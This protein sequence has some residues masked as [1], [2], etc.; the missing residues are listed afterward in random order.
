MFVLRIEGTCQRRV[1]VKQLNGGNCGR[2]S[3]K[4]NLALLPN[5]QAVSDSAELPEYN[6]DD[7][8][9]HCMSIKRSEIIPILKRSRRNIDLDTLIGRSGAGSVCTGCHLLLR[10]MAGDVVWTP[11]KI[12]SIKKV[13]D[14]TKT[15]RF[16]STGK[17]FHPARA[18]QHIIVQSYIDGRWELRRYTLTTPAEETRY[19]EIT[20][21]RKSGGKFS[22]WL[23]RCE[24]SENR[25]RISQPVGDVT[26]E[27]A[28]SKP[29]IC[30]VG[31]I[32][33][34]PVISFIRTIHEKRSG[35]RP[36]V[37]DYSELHEERLVY[38]KELQEI[39]EQNDHINVNFR[40][41]DEN[42][43]INQ[44]DIN[45]LLK[46]YPDGEFYVCGPPAFSKGIISCLSK[47]GVTQDMI[48]MEF[49]TAPEPRKINPSKFYFYLGL[50]LFS[51]FLIQD[52]LR[53]KIPWLENLQAQEGYKIYSGIFLVLYILM[54]FVMPYN[55]SCEKPHVSAKTYRQHKFRGALAPLIFY[56]HSTKFGSSY[57]LLL[58]SVYFANF[59]VGLFNHERIKNAIKRVA[60]FK[61]WLPV[62]ISLSVLILSLI[63]FHVYVLSSY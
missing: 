10:E 52:S 16:E 18:G 17:P 41:T 20:V 6:D 15:Y 34:T 46:K 50:A 9:C 60:Y 44:D 4:I 25:I 35:V 48:S 2:Q 3:G 37:I 23:Y 58:S 21:R 32:G 26:L 62:H 55:K 31:G 30:L 47:A 40:L 29:L 36:L 59:L 63:V 22:N 12:S 61:F 5:T 19:R 33:V 56:V 24:K 14:N 1:S 28:N 38:K 7:P 45:R 54:Q 51:I 8:V 49:F 42:G 57:L 43:F 39:S 13:S 53:L 27:L 11:V